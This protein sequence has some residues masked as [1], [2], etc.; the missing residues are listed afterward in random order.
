[1]DGIRDASGQTSLAC[2]D[3]VRGQVSRH[4]PWPGQQHT[5][6]T[7]TATACRKAHQNA[8]FL[9]LLRAEGFLRLDTGVWGH[10]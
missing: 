8:A 4:C 9:G 5:P 6:A 3:Q 2:W 1:M 10:T 7:A